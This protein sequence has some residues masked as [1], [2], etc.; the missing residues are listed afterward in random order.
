MPAFDLKMFAANMV[1][2]AMRSLA[3][4]DDATLKSFVMTARQHGHLTN[5]ETE[6]YIAAWGLEA[7]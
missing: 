6:F 1:K 5:E 2:A 7:A 3:S 4:E